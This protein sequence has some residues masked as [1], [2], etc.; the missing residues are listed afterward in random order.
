MDAEYLRTHIGG[1]WHKLYDGAPVAGRLLEALLTESVGLALEL[2]LLDAKPAT[3]VRP[4]GLRNGISA[5]TASSAADPV[6]AMLADVTTV[7]SAVAT[8]ATNGPI[9][10]VTSPDQAVLLRTRPQEIGYQIYPHCDCA[11][12][13]G[14]RDGPGAEVRGREGRAGAHGRPQPAGRSRPGSGVL[15]DEEANASRR[16]PATP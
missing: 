13:I 8:V 1:G 15:A 12:R 5:L 11:E 10:L 16:T 7:V 6:T 3:A 14:K 2:A 9:V 4:A